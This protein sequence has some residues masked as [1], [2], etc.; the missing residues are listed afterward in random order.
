[1]NKLFIKKNRDRMRYELSRNIYSYI[2]NLCNREALTKEQVAA[3]P[4]T[5]AA[6]TVQFVDALIDELAK[7]GG[8]E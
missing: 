8:K 5:A 7:K 2:I 4:Q 6:R 3:L 1:M